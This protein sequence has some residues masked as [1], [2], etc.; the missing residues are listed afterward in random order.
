M[1][2]AEK[3]EGTGRDETI[4]GFGA[5]PCGVA[6]HGFFRRRRLGTAG[7]CGERR[8]GG[9]LQCGHRHRGVREERSRGAGRRQPHQDDDRPAA[10]GE[11][12]GPV[13]DLHHPRGPRGGVRPHPGGERLGRGPED[14]RD[15]HAGKPALCLPS[16]QRQ[17]RRQRH[18]LLPGQW[19]HAGLL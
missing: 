17:R 13:P 3:R 18:R 5:D 10:G 9:A 11:R 1:K 2:E 7:G 12:R 19:G 4:S 16:A 6:D 14:R 8:S 15:G